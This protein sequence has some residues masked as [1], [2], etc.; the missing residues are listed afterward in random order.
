MLVLQ[1]AAIQVEQPNFTFRDLSDQ[2]DIQKSQLQ[3]LAFEPHQI[4]FS[5]LRIWDAMNTLLTSAASD[6]CGI[7]TG[8]P[9]TD[10]PYVTGG[11]VKNATTNRKFAFELAVPPNY[12]DGFNAR[13]RFRA[14]MVTTVASSAA[15][16]DLEAF[17]PNGSGGVGSDLCVTSAQSINSLTLGNFNFDLAVSTIDP[18][19][20]I[21]CIVTLSVVDSATATAVI[22]GVFDIRGLFH[23][24]G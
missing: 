23:T 24:R 10:S 19:D 11:D 15:T 1:N 5:D 14:G 7:T 8:T 13:V 2:A 6:D 22:P 20:K 16:I 21:I 9:G 17:R 3:Q 18:G 12:D 4:P